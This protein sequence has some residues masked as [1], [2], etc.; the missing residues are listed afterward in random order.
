[1]GDKRLLVRRVNTTVAAKDVPDGNTFKYISKGSTTYCD[2]IVMRR[3]SSFRVL[4][5][6][7]IE[8]ADNDVLV[9]NVT[10]QCFGIVER[11]QQVIQTESELV[12]NG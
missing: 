6:C 11:N 2:Y 3:N 8:R 5:I 7:G 4:N 9:Y 12:I 1:M 10:A